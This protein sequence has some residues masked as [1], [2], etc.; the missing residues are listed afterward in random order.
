VTT[1]LIT[2]GTPEVLQIYQE[3]ALRID[4]EPLKI[5][6]DIRSANIF[7]KGKN[8]NKQCTSKVKGKRR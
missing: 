5:M 1:D 7:T 6:Q 4:E 3:E 2:K 8:E